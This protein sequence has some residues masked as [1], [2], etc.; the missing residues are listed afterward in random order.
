MKRI[1]III[2]LYNDE[3]YIERSLRSVCNQSISDQ[4]EV[5]IIAD[6][7]TDNSVAIARS[8]LDLYAGHISTNL[9]TLTHNKGVANARKL[10]I[11]EAKGEYI[12]F[13]DSDDWMDMMMCEKMLA[14]AD[15]SGCEVVVCD[16]NSVKDGIVKRVGPCYY[17]DFL[18]QLIMCN[19]T[20]SLC[21][22]MIRADLFRRPDFRF[23]EYDFSED[24]VYCIQVA[25]YAKTIGYVPEY[26][27][28][29]WKR[30]D[31]FVRCQKP[32]IVKKRHDDDIANL[33]LEQTILKDVDLFDKYCGEMMVRKLK[34][35]NTYRDNR[36]LWLNTYPELWKEVYRSPYLPWRARVS[37]Y[38]RLLGIKL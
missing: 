9:I 13:C 19:I 37:F 2:P 28:Y 22:K 7:C 14:K 24:H 10:G 33:E 25:V 8:V 30:N 1:S 29:Y 6:G 11:V 38:L 5:I 27:Y 23:P 16:Y 3:R 35:K 36:K 21:N 26:L 15:D 34:T 4:L 17:D 31:S 32:E 18:R 20:G 12:M